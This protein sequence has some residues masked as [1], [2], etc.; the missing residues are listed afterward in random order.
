MNVC[1]HTKFS[2][3]DVVVNS[4]GANELRLGSELRRYHL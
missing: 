1:V 4:T 3:V 2:L